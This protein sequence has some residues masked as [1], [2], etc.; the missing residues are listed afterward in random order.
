LADDLGIGTN[1]K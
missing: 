1:G